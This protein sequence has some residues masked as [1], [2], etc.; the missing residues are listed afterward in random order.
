MISIFFILTA[1]TAKTLSE[2]TCVNFQGHTNTQFGI[3]N[4]T[5]NI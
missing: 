3:F 4:L 5:Q 1:K 2:R